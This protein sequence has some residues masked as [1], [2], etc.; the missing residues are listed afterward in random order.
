MKKEGNTQREAKDEIQWDSYKGLVS[1][2][3]FFADHRATD[4][5]II[6][7]LIKMVDEGAG[8]ILMPNGRMTPMINTKGMEDYEIDAMS[9]TSTRYSRTTACTDL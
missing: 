5:H 6:R 1:R 4:N 8:V 7:K 2:A 9:T 3:T